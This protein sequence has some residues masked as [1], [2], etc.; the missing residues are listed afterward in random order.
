MSLY[1]GP[2]HETVCDSL[3]YLNL[4]LQQRNQLYIFHLTLK[5]GWGDGSVEKTLASRHEDQ[6]VHK[7]QADAATAYNPAHRRQGQRI[8]KASG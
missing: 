3:I 5:E 6:N 7:I 4:V 8:P 2:F 1:G